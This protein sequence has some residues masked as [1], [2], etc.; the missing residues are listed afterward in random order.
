MGEI[1]MKGSKRRRQMPKGQ[2]PVAAD[3]EPW[4]EIGQLSGQ[5]DTAREVMGLVRW[6]QAARKAAAV[7]ELGP[8]RAAQLAQRGLALGVLVEE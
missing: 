2:A 6:Y 5:L 1:P 7:G 3:V 4:A 8:D